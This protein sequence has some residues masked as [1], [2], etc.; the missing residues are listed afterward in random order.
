MERK[1]MV[2][3]Y[4]NNRQKQNQR[5][6]CFEDVLTRFEGQAMKSDKDEM[7]ERVLM[8]EQTGEINAKK[9]SWHDFCILEVS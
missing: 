5:P 7:Q 6:I 8:G 3:S 9:K 2:S 1:N 4:Y